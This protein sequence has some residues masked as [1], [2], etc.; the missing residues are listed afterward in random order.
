MTARNFMVQASKEADIGFLLRALCE[1]TLLTP[2]R[3]VLVRPLR[4]AGQRSILRCSV[5][6]PSRRAIAM[7]PAATSRPP[8]YRP[9]LACARNG[10]RDS[11]EHT[12]SRN[13]PAGE[14]GPRAAP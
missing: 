2:R 11:K 13:F 10:E 8:A 5:R 3:S 6:T 9:E 4:V 1:Q 12:I 7:R 14:S